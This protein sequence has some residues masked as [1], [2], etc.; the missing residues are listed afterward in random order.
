MKQIALYV[1]EHCG[2]QY[3]EKADAQKCE[4]NHKQPKEVGGCRYLS[5]KIDA[6]GYPSTIN[7]MFEDGSM[8]QYKR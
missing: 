3:A 4:K 6:S 2:T 8:R 5:I 1:C 7:I